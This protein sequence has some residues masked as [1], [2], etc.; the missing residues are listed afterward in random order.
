MLKSVVGFRK[1]TAAR[2]KPDSST[3]RADLSARIFFVRPLVFDATYGRC[4]LVIKINH[5]PGSP[6]LLAMGK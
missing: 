1:R 4:Q 5:R 2:D 3:R 6:L